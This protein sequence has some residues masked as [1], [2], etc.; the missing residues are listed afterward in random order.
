MNPTHYRE[1][2]GVI[3]TEN[4]SF[5]FIE[6]KLSPNT[7]RR[8]GHKTNSVFCKYIHGEDRD[9]TT[10]SQE[11]ENVTL[12]TFSPFGTIK[13]MK[14]NISLNSLAHSTQQ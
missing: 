12:M 4:Y 13:E 11:N 6:K 3:P 9:K 1:M 7:W 10:P 8:N 2:L 14:W 5:E